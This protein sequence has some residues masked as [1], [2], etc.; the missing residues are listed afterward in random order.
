ME[1]RRSRRCF[2]DTAQGEA[3]VEA[4]AEDYAYL[5]F[6]LLELFQAGG[7]PAWLE[8]ALTLQRRLD[9]LFWDP[10]TAA[11]SARRA[12]IRRCCCG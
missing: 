6:G 11:G 10:S 7:D 8:W 3:G 9:E 2:A 1:S 4:Y 12:R 5:I